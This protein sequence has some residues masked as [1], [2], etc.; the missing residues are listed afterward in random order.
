MCVCRCASKQTQQ[1]THT[2]KQKMELSKNRCATSKYLT[3]FKSRRIFVT[4]TFSKHYFLFVYL[5][6]LKRII[7]KTQNLTFCR[8]K[9]IFPCVSCFD[10]ASE[11]IKMKC[12]TSAIFF[13]HAQN[14]KSK[15]KTYIHFEVVVSTEI[16]LKQKNKQVVIAGCRAFHEWKV[17][18]KILNTR[19]R[20]YYCCSS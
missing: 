11:N 17:K 2:L 14:R 13:Y 18:T 12:E 16:H 6:I 10:V 20:C 5:E 9:C 7:K 4:T 19:K 1:H 3:S 8:S 15:T